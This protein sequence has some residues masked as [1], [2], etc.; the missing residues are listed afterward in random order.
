[1]T[2]TQAYIESKS[3]WIASYRVRNGKI[4]CLMATAN[5]LGS[6]WELPNYDGL[7]PWGATLTF[8]GVAKDYTLVGTHA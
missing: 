5:G 4:M 7:F 6:Y 1:M 8:C 2:Q 3:N